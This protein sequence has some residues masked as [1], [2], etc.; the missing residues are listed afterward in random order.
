MQLKIRKINGNKICLQTNM[1]VEINSWRSNLFY[2]RP[3]HNM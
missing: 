3:P 1:V 2:Y